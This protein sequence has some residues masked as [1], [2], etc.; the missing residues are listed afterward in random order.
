M[1]LALPPRV[2]L[3]DVLRAD[4]SAYFWGSQEGS[5]LSALDG[6]A[7]TYLAYMTEP[8]PTIKMSRSGSAD[9]GDVHLQ[10]LAGNTIERDVAK[11]LRQREFEG[12][13]AVYRQH[14]IFEDTDDFLFHGFLRNQQITP[15]EV[16][17]RMT[18]LFAPADVPAYDYYQT[19]Q[20]HFRYRSAQCGMRMGTLFVP[21]IGANIFSASTIGNSGLTMVPNLFAGEV[22]AIRGGTGAGQERFIA[23]HTATTIT[24]T[25][26]WSPT[27]DITSSFLVT[28]PGTRLVSWTGAD[29]FS[30]STIGFSSAGWG[31]NAY[32]GDLVVIVSGTG[33]GQERLITGNSA[34]TLSVSPNWT[35]T[36]DATSQFIVVYRDCP[37]TRTA[38]SDRGVIERFP[39]IITLTSQVSQAATP[40]TV[41]VDNG[42]GVVDNS[43]DPTF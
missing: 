24:P 30:A 7:H 1:T 43:F 5:F 26:N 9:G 27:P 34:S 3:L 23:S 21:R 38:C 32:T 39:G 31:V 42:G 18:Q 6:A 14:S 36:P 2:H 17:F 16:L 15:Q 4:G 22:V 11:L 28:G 41:P 10:N 13:Y 35:V 8:Y 37:K 12:A 19:L 33:A 25:V 29:I 20:C 40:T